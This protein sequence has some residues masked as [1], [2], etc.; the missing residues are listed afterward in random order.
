VKKVIVAVL[1][2]FVVLCAGNA[3]AVPM[4]WS[5]NGHYYDV[6][7]GNWT[8]NSAKTNAE[9]RSYSGMSGHLATITTPEENTF[10]ITHFNTW[11]WVGGYQYDNLAEPYGHWAWVTGEAWGNPVW[12]K[13]G[14]DN[15]GGNEQYVELI[16]SWG[17]LN[18]LNG[19][20]MR[21]SY[22]IE[23]EP[24]NTAVPEPASIILFGLGLA[25]ISRLKRRK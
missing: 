3:F 11:S 16:S 21:G 4:M 12:G 14:A 24:V 22:V 10:I 5:S 17:G 23:Y 13:Y 6:I 2:V 8:W 18:D 1:T 15:S 19:S 7:S 9:S 25:G 20:T